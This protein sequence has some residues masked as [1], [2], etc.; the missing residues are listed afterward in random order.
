MSVEIKPYTEKTEHAVASVIFASETIRVAEELKKTVKGGIPVITKSDYQDE[1][2]QTDPQTLQILK[3]W[4]FGKLREFRAD[5]PELEQ[6][7]YKSQEAN[8]EVP[9][10]PTQLFPKRAA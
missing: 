8:G 3:G 9:A 2:L 6:D 5:N 4:I 1:E 7:F 10:R